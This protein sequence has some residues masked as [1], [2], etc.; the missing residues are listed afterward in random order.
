M[1]GPTTKEAKVKGTFLKDQRVDASKKKVKVIDEKKVVTSS[2]CLSGLD[3][4]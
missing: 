2:R 4:Y 3:I 1:G